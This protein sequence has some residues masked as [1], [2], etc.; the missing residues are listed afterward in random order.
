MKKKFTLNL[1]SLIILFSI[2]H[3]CDDLQAQ[4]FSYTNVGPVFLQFPY[5]P[6]SVRYVNRLAV[7]RNNSSDTIHFRFARIVN[8]MPQGWLTQMGYDLSYP[9][10]IDTI[11]IPQ[12]PPLSI[13]P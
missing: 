9:W 13:P 7:V 8:D 11:S 2:L 12:D 5:N 10:F 1:I 4:S 3:L 6:D